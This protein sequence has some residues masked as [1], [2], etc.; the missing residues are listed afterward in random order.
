LS[1]VLIRGGRVIDPASGIDSIG[2]IKFERGRIV[3]DFGGPQGITEV[4]AKGMLVVPGLI[5]MHVHLRDP[6]REDEETIETGARAAAAGGFTTVVC[7]P[8]TEPPID[9]RSVV[10]YIAEKASGAPVDIKV[11]GAIS[12]GL[13]GEGL[14]LMGELAAAGVVG[15]SDDG[16]PVSDS[17]LMRRAMEYSRVF[18]LPIISHCEDMGLAAGGVM[19]EGPVSTRL[20]LRGIPAAAEEIMVARDILLAELTGAKVHITHVSTAGA[21]EIIRAAKRRGVSLSAD[22]TPHHLALTDACLTGYDANYKVNPPLRSGADRK[23]L[24]AGLIDGTIDAIASDHAPHA[25]HEK[26]GEI[27]TAPCGT[28]GLQTTV[29]VLM[30]NLAGVMDLSALIGKMTVEPAR[31]LGLDKGSLRSGQSA[32]VTIIDPKARLEIRAEYFVSKSQNSVFIDT[33]LSG[34]VKHVWSAGRP[35]VWDGELVE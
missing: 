35:V 13:S 18:G 30:T 20:G 15:F 29:P 23:A 7:M 8:N 6:G 4:D 1:R 25:A 21:V 10:D 27:E 31:I 34:A 24:I 22:V 2:D 33:E 28:I 19:H 16:R 5:D 9:N 14:S 12:A 11:V 3:D 32:D 26:E 17:A